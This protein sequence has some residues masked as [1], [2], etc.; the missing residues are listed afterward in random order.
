MRLN[1]KPNCSGYNYVRKSYL[2]T[3]GHEA[4]YIWSSMVSRYFFWLL[5]IVED[6]YFLIW[7]DIVVL[8]KN[9]VQGIQKIEQKTS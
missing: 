7:Q 3:L 8:V 1:H 4:L 5:G 9:K 6:I 2:S